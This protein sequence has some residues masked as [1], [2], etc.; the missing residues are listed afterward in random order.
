MTDFAVFGHPADHS[1]SP[2]LHSLLGQRTAIDVSYDKRTI[3]LAS[4]EEA[5]SDFFSQEGGRGLNIT[6]PFKERAFHLCDNTTDR[7]NNAQAVNTL[8]QQQGQLYGDNTDGAGIITDLT[9]RLQ[10]QLHNKQL[11]ILGAGGSVRGIVDSLLQTQP[12]QCTIANRTLKRAQQ[13]VADCQS[14]HTQ[15]PIYACGFEQLTGSYDYIIN[16][17]S[18]SL[19]EQHIP[20]SPSILQST[21]AC[22]DLG[23]SAKGT[24]RFCQWAQQHGCQNLSDG[25]GML[26]EQG[27]ESFRIWHGVAADTT[28]LIEELQ[29]S[30]L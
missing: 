15:V 5:V 19:G 22:Y 2:I 9:A 27:A 6:I 1:L 10:W 24:T 20:F 4:F 11:L 12:A 26:V 23:Y 25:L 16:A 29:K 30:S 18:I 21:T 7:A 28:G 3:A 8:W 14:R 13:L 17:T